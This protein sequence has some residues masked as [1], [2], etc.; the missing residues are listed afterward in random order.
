MERHLAQDPEACSDAR[1]EA[2][3]HCLGQ[4]APRPRR[5]L[6][7]QHREGLGL[8]AIAAELGTGVDSIKTMLKRARA[9]LRDCARR[10]Q[11][12]EER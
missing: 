9:W 5:A 1:L 8:A 7:L 12:E 11:V 6:D 4:L 10:R 3:R 2:L